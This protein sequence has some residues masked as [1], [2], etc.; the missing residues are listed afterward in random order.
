MRLSDISGIHP[1]FSKKKDMTAHQLQILAYYKRL[2]EAYIILLTKYG[3]LYHFYFM[4][5]LFWRAQA[6]QT[7]S[8]VPLM[9][10][11]RNKYLAPCL[12]MVLHP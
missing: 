8:Y 12:S 5:S 3:G 10:L 2:V 9:F 11:L 4:F 6:P 1:F 7:F